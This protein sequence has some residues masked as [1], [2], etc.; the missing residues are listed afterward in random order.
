MTEGSQVHVCC[1]RVFSSIAY[2]WMEYHVLSIGVCALF[3]LFFT[4]TCICQDSNE[5]RCLWSVFKL[6]WFEDFDLP[7]VSRQ[8]RLKLALLNDTPMCWKI[9]IF[10]NGCNLGMNF[11]PSISIP[12]ENLGYP[13]LVCKK[14]FS[15]I[16]TSADKTFLIYQ[17]RFS[18]IFT[19]ADKSYLT[20][21][22][23][24]RGIDKKRITTR[25]VN[26]LAV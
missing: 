24:T 22:Y 19:S 16:F 26:T 9:D 25:V 4:F 10:R 1:P 5:T 7:D 8:F 14:R 13:Y 21:P 3:P 20:Y 18:A 12:S 6:L 17:T 2:N 11:I 15:A 23:P